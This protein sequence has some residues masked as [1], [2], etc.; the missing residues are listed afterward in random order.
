MTIQ[1]IQQEIIDEFSFFDDWQNRY[2]YIIEMGKSLPPFQREKTDN[3]VIK[4]CQ[5][6]VWLYMTLKDDKVYM[7]M[8]SD[9]ILPKGITALLVKMYNN[10]PPE[11]ILNSDISFIDKIGLAEFLSPIRA[12]GLLAMIKQIKYYAVALKSKKDAG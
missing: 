12:N 7:E 2:E 3:L 11:D 8:D 4:G 9:S 1:Q 5:S 10:Q 6:K